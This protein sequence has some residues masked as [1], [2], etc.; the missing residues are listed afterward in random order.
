MRYL[1]IYSFTTNLVLVDL[2]VRLAG[3]L[4]NQLPHIVLPIFL[5]VESEI[6]RV[7]DVLHPLEFGDLVPEFGEMEVLVQVWPPI[8]LQVEVP[9]ICY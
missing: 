4:L 7:V 1:N 2:F 3:D 8:E 6:V 9:I 5:P